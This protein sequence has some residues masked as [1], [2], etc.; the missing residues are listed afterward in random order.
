MGDVKKAPSLFKTLDIL[1]KDFKGLRGMVGSLED[2]V[3]GDVPLGEVYELAA[4][5]RG[6]IDAFVET[7]MAL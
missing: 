2:V 4:S 1:A 7:V 5:F 3:E 6:R